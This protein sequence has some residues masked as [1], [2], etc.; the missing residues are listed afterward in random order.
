MSKDRSNQVSESR[1][2]DLLHKGAEALQLDLP[3]RALQMLWEH[4]KLLT[5]WSQK[6][7]LTTVLDLTGMVE[8]LYLDSAILLP[9]LSD[10]CRLHDVGSGAGFPG[11]I[12]KALSPELELVLTEAR[13]KRV[14]FLKQAARVM[15][16]DQ[17][18][19]IVWH[20]LGQEKQGEEIQSAM[21]VVSRATFPPEVWVEM[22]AK[23]VEPGGRLWIM[24]G[25]PI[26]EGDGEFDLGILEKQPELSLE[27]NLRYQLPF[28]GLERWLIALR[29]AAET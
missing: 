19:E 2:F 10:D 3:A 24:S 28:C 20:R 16:L 7:N 25:Q 23:L 26:G 29:K 13:H 8:R 15:G 18:L 12:L 22:G 9:Y 27:L 5:K 11:L 6:M 17:G 21:E 1:F 14:S 4:Q